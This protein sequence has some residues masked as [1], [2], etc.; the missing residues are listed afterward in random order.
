[1]ADL[2]IPVLEV[3][4]M[5]YGGTLGRRG[6]PLSDHEMGLA[7][8]IFQGSIDY[9]AV[10]IVVT[11]V[12]AAPTTLGNNIRTP[13]RAMADRVLIH[14]LTHI[15]QYQTRGTGYISNSVC[16]QV[17]AIIRTGDR[18]AAY[19]YRDQLG[20]PSIYDYNAEQQAHIVEDY[21]ADSDLANNEHYQRYMRQVRSARPV[22]TRQER[23]NEAM[24]GDTGT[25]RG[26][27]TLAQPPTGI[28]PPGTTPI[29]RLEW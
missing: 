28:E 25:G 29:F 10:R 26:R 18:N 20:R 9:D 17:G 8:P 11:S 13:Q 19:E 7:R 15:W 1:M 12:I 14:E 22:M 27:R 16:A 23:Y 2:R 3:L 5:Q 24:F 21:F 6:V 4:G